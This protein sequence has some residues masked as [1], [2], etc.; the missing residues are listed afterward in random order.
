MFE[1]Y[2]YVFIFSLIG[3][4]FS[5]VATLLPEFIA[6]KHKGKQARETYESGVD[7]IGSAWVQFKSTYYMYA[8]IF[9]VFDVEVVFLFPALLAYRESLD[10]NA[11]LVAMVFLIILTL[12]IV[13]AIRNKF[14]TWK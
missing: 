7:T 2:V 3:L 6:P 9:I 8:L 10:L 5:L 14:L 13:Y 1:N 11:F 12:G 4:G